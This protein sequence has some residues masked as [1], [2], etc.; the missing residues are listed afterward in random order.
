MGLAEGLCK[1]IVFKCSLLEIT[2]FFVMTVP[3]EILGD[4]SG[5]Q[6]H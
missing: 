2:E 6:F 4:G 3:D 5:I 1:D